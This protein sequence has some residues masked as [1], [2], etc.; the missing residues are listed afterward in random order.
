MEAGDSQSEGVG[1]DGC[2]GFGSVLEVSHPTLLHHLL[3]SSNIG[4]QFFFLDVT[5]CIMVTTFH[6]YLP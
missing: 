6:N 1:C 2:Q 5:P 3:S 4:K